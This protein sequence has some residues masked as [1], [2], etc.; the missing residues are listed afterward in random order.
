[1]YVYMYVCMYVSMCAAHV[2]HV[3]LDKGAEVWL[4]DQEC[5]VRN[6]GTYYKQVYYNYS[7]CGNRAQNLKAVVVIQGFAQQNLEDPRPFLI[8]NNRSGPQQYSSIITISAV[9]N[10]LVYKPLW[11]EYYQ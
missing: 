11:Q 2:E 8:W 7:G 10:I 9:W 3:P 4:K 6:T 5:G 1:M